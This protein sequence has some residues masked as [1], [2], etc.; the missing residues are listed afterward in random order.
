LQSLYSLPPF[1]INEARGI[2]SRE[3]GTLASGNNLKSGAVLGRIML[4]GLYTEYNPTNS[5]G[6]EEA[7]A[8]LYAAKDASAADTKCVVIVRDCEV[9]QTKLIWFDGAVSTQKELGIL[10]LEAVGIICR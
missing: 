7:V 1:L 2:R 3:V 5:D 6:S 9:N 8:L 4:S 10:D